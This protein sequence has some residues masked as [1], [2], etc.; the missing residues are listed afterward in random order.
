MPNPGGFREAPSV[1]DVRPPCQMTLPDRGPFEFPAPYGTL[2][3]RLTHP[4]DMAGQDAL[5]DVG[6][7]YWRRIN[8]HAGLSHLL[9]LLGIERN[10][11]GA[12]PSLYKVDKAS[13]QVEPLGPVFPAS[14]PLSWQTA[15]NW[16]W[17]ATDPYLLFAMDD[18]H[19]YRVDVLDRAVTTV[20]AAV[21]ITPY[22]AL[23]KRL[24]QWHSSAD[25]R[26]HSA[27]VKEAVE[28]NA[29][30]GS[31][32]YY[33]G[34][35]PE[36]AFVF[37]PARGPYDECQLDKSGRYLVIKENVDGLEGEDNVI[38]DLWAGTQRVLTDPKGAGGHSD[39]GFGY[40]VAADNW[41]GQPNAVRLWMLDEAQAPQGRVVY[42]GANWNADL[43]HISHANAQPGGPDGQFVV[44]SGANRKRQPR[45]N[46]IL[47]F[48][49][50]GQCEAVV[51]A[52][53]LVDL[54]APGGGDDYR[55]LP[56]GNLDATGEWFVW[57]A[58]HGSD[59]LDA[60]LVR[61]PTGLL[62]ETR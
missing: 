60:F 36:T 39:L 57:T 18:E 12:G 54:D 13:G 1:R 33:E 28:P 17:H 11:G 8:A 26:V 56:K 9:V 29:A 38:V 15:E 21:D 6:Y 27:T 10:R 55:K 50:D 37:L 4:S 25:G 44:G 58:N 5:W 19:L 46:E 48:R 61:V 49:L 42:E 7:S 16:Y 40:M 52:P 53:N 41:N 30:I 14:H 3:I 22:R 34:R 20:V 23:S 43:N 35:P 31:L 32:V 45:N 62:L 24:R 51:I 2:G 47:G 59:R